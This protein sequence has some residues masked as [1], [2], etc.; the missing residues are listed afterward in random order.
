MTDALTDKYPD[1]SG[2]PDFA[3]INCKGNTY[4]T[5]GGT[6]KRIDYLMYWKSDNVTMSTQEF[7]MPFYKT[8]NSK[9][10]TISLSDHEALSVKFL[11][12]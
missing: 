10:E 5:P 4:S 1:A 11:I 9:G 7:T 12:E 3:T 8:V 2:S 6:P